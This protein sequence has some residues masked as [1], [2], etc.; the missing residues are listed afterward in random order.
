MSRHLTSPAVID[1]DMALN[2]GLAGL[3]ADE[4]PRDTEAGWAARG[5]GLDAGQADAVAA[6]AGGAGLEV[7]VGPAGTG[8][9][10]ML[11][12][13]QAALRAQGRELVVLAPTRKAAQVA[14][15]ELGA[16]ASS[17]A[18]LLYDHGWRWDDLGRY[19]RPAVLPGQPLPPGGQAH[20]G[21]GPPRAGGTSWR[22][23]PRSVVVVDEAGL[24][25]VD[26]AVALI[27]VVRGS[28]ASL[29]LVG[30][31]RQ[32]GAVGRGGVMETA[33]PLGTRGRGHPQPGAPFPTPRGRP[34]R[35]AGNRPRRELGAA[36][37]AVA[38]RG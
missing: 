24:L 10:A 36:V 27:D 34:R 30:D 22:S 32:L 1:A 7:V 16:P 13:A 21:P 28:G 9:T 38:G 11:A 5:A 19:S 29:R 3:A 31:P 8:K 20:R 12:A 25:S 18:K 14:S 6:I 35:P 33:G 17:V 26:Q 4:G 23:R 2:L 15:E 37:R